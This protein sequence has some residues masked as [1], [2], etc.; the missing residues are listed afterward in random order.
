[1]LSPGEYIY[2]VSSR[3]NQTFEP[4][5]AVSTQTQLT[6]Y[7]FT[8]PPANRN[9]TVL[10]P[11]ELKFLKFKFKKKSIVQKLVRCVFN[12]LYVQLMM[13]IKF[14]CN[15]FAPVAYLPL[16]HLGHAPLAKNA[17]YGAYTVFGP[18]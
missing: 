5:S 15:N 16:G 8:Q 2:S 9:R 18:C 10:D 7:E 17:T 13:H 12:M 1:V 14:N 6:I 11:A 3:A 4:L